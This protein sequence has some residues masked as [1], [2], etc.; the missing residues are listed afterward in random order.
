MPHAPSAEREGR[1]VQP[2][3]DETGVELRLAVAAVVERVEVGGADDDEGGVAAEL[4]VEADAVEL[5]AQVAGAHGGLEVG[6]AVEARLDARRR[7]GRRRSA[8][9][10]CRAARRAATTRRQSRRSD[11]DGVE[12]PR[13][14]AA[15]DD[16]VETGRGPAARR[17]S[18]A[19]DGTRSPRR[20][21]SPACC[22]SVTSGNSTRRAHVDLAGRRVD[23][24]AD[25][26]LAVAE[27]HDGERELVHAV[28]A[29]EPRHGGVREDRAQA[30]REAGVVAERDGVREDRPGVPVEVAEAALRVAPAGAPGDAGERRASSPRRPARGPTCTSAWC[31]GSNQCT[32][33]GEPVD[34]AR[35]DVEPRTGTGRRP[36]PPRGSGSAGR[37]CARRC[38][39]RR[40]R[41]AAGAPGARGRAWPAARHAGRRAR[42]WP[43]RRPAATSAAAPTVG[44]PAGYVLQCAG[45]VARSLGSKPCTMR[46]SSLRRVPLAVGRVGREP[47]VQAGGVAGRH[48]AGSLPGR[49][50]PLRRR[51]AAERADDRRQHDDRVRGPQ[52]RGDARLHRR[53]VELVLGRDAGCVDLRRQ[54]AQHAGE[55]RRTARVAR[56]RST[57]GRRSRRR[58]RGRP[59]AGSARAAY[60]SRGRRGRRG[61]QRSSSPRAWS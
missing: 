18:G 59:A 8:A 4:L 19:P 40:R 11:R 5:L 52:A 29:D 47:V 43:S 9:P 28:G 26:R 2:A 13:G 1:E 3:V 24:R 16:V 49:A 51:A 31:S 7:R 58:R 50:S 20:S 25:G 38:A 34:G 6:P 27:R 22:A 45:N 33:S 55:Q 54:R 23:R 35:R 15:Q 53:Q 61:R 48:R 46:G 57:P 56:A 37:R 32:P 30:R 44:S 12:E 42:R 39:R 36:S 17:L 60:R 10:R 21:P 41:G 14:A